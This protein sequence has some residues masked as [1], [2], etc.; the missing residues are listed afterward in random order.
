MNTLKILL[1]ILIPTSFIIILII[2]YLY[3]KNKKKINNI[4]NI[5]YILEQEF[6][7]EA[8]HVLVE[9]FILDHNV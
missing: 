1:I 7:T 5:D 2:Y 8:A 3:K 6:D 4:E 9:S